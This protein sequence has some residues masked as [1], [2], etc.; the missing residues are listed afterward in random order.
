MARS[1]SAEDITAPSFFTERTSTQISS[2]DTP[3]AISRSAS[4][5]TAWAWARSERQRQ[6]RTRPP[7]APRSSL[8]IRSGHGSHHGA[9]GREDAPAGAVVALEADHL[10]VGELAL[11]VEEV[12]LRGAAE[13]V[14]RLVVVAHHG[15]VAV[16]VHQQPEQ[17]PLG[18]VRVL[19]LVH[20]HVPVALRRALAHVRAL[21]QQPEGAHHEIAEV[22][23]AALRQQAVVVGVDA[24]ELDLAGRASA[25]AASPSSSA[26]ATSPSA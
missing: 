19:V 16:R 7:L 24:G 5:A 1:S 21:V 22:E 23:R 8:P 9:G 4:A 6:K 17:H 18:E 12:L 14:D 11:E 13:A 15:H 25:R 20:E 3:S 10:G 2:G 26:A